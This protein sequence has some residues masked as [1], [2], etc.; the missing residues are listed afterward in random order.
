MG[1]NDNYKTIFAKGTWNFDGCDN[2][3]GLDKFVS[4]G[5]GSGNVVAVFG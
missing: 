5:S 4:G 1:Y 2:V 3:Y